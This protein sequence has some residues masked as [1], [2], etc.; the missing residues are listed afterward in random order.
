M[1]DLN[2]IFEAILAGEEPLVFG[3]IVADEK[4]LDGVLD[5]F[6]R[7]IDEL[8][9]ERDA[10]KRELL[11]LKAKELA[12]IPELMHAAESSKSPAVKTFASKVLRKYREA[13]EK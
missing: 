12:T 11:E 13:V 5:F 4:S 10:L 2:A 8:R 7:G 9:K 6:G 3:A 1:N